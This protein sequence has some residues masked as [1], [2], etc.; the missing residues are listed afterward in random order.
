MGVGDC[1]RPIFSPSKKR[2]ESYISAA[3]LRIPESEQERKAGR[4]V[5][6]AMNVGN[7]HRRVFVTDLLHS[8]LGRFGES[9]VPAS[10]LTRIRGLI[11]HFDRL[12]MQA[13]TLYP[14]IHGGYGGR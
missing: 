3:R 5:L 6:V 14:L 4:V 1:L 2:G 10:E 11:Q 9:H 8:R 12:V 7:G 13:G